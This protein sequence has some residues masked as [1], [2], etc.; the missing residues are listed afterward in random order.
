MAAKTLDADRR[1]ALGFG[2]SIRYLKL[3]D[4]IT[5]SSGRRSVSLIDSM[6]I[7]ADG[8]IE[9][10]FPASPALSYRDGN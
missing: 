7:V 4:T 8:S 9:S 10:H 3:F 2:L 5:S 1:P 6:E